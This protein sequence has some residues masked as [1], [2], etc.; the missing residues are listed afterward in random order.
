MSGT[1]F[2][3]IEED[4]PP[5]KEG[6]LELAKKAPQPKDDSFLNDVKDYGK[7]FLK[8]LVE[9]TQRLGKIMGPLQSYEGK[10]SQEEQEQVTEELDKLLPTD[11]GF[12][13]RGMRRGLKE[14]PTALFFPGSVAQTL[15][16]AIA[17][18]YAAEGAKELGAPEW[19]Q[20]A[21]EL[22]AYIGPDLTKKLLE[23]GNDKK[24][25]QFGRKSGISDEAMAPLLN[26]EFKQKWLGKLSPRRGSTQ[27]ALSKSKEE[28]GEAYEKIKKSPNS[29]NKLGESS[30]EKIIGDIDETLFEMP[31]SVREKISRDYSDLISKPITGESLINFYGDINHSL[32]PSSKQLSLLKDPIKNALKEV[33]PELEKDFG[34]INDLFSRYYKISKRLEPNLMTDLIGASEVLGL[35][36]SFTLGYYPTLFK[37]AGEKTA[38]KVAQQLLINPR[39]HQLSGKMVD[40]LNQNKFIM[41]KKISDLISKE[42]KKTSP[43]IAQELD[44]ISEEDFKELLKKHQP[45]E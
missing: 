25:I 27:K 18:G 6:Y 38:R 12:I 24:L 7:T 26:S 15:P 13:Q 28:L 43:E 5:G 45:N 23:K 35:L 2:D 1:I 30:T 39:F 31:S 10:T 34:M 9:G 42:I 36:G 8:G 16:R 44:K 33:S 20:S 4:L 41:A 37:F 14:A 11:E 29:I 40:A 32:G 21:A 3:L 17:G 19:L 22:T